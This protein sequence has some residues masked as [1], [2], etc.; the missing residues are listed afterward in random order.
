MEC[1][2]KNIK[3]ANWTKVGDVYRIWEGNQRY[4]DDLYIAGLGNR[5]EGG[6][7][8]RDMQN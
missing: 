4:K 2:L 6:T 3:E 5:I 7:I 1:S 8:H